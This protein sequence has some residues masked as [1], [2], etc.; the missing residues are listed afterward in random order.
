MK[1]L[2]R[3]LVIICI[4][5]SGLGYAQETKIEPMDLTNWDQ[6]SSFTD[7][8]KSLNGYI[9]L[10]TTLH[11]VKEATK[12][13]RKN[14]MGLKGLKKELLSENSSFSKNA[15]LGNKIKTT[16]NNFNG[17]TG[18][19]STSLGKEDAINTFLPLVMDASLDTFAASIATAPLSQ[20]ASITY[21]E[22]INTLKSST[23]E[24]C[25]DTYSVCLLGAA[26]ETLTLISVQFSAAGAFFMIR[27]AYTVGALTPINLATLGVSVGAALVADIIGVVKGYKEC[28]SAYRV[29][30]RDSS[31]ENR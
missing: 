8:E 21:N 31:I 4:L 30:E 16:I 5:S 13:I 28:S 26:Q 9:S 6:K 24:E 14:G 10:F 11:E 18:L 7:R 2:K 3:I 20:K 1:K 29:C 22:A 17:R 25:R 23:I 19:K 15:D 27:E 12:M